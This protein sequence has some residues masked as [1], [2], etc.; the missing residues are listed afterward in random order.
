[1]LAAVEEVTSAEVEEAG[2]QEE[3]ADIAAVAEEA[4]PEAEGI[5]AVVVATHI[6]KNSKPAGYEAA[7]FFSLTRSR[8]DNSPST[9]QSVQGGLSIA[10]YTASSTADSSACLERQPQPE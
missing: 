5:V 9:A 8:S 10:S 7:G 6:D 4:T 2:M 3:V 1:M